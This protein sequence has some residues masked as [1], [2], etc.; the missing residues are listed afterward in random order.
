MTKVLHINS[1]YITTKLYRDLL[2]QLAPLGVLSTT[3]MF[4][5]GG[6][7]YV[8][9]EEDVIAVPTHNTLDRINYFT[10]HLKTYRDLDKRMKMDDQ[11]DVLHA[12]SLFSNGAIA[13]LISKKYKIPY[14]VAVRDT[15][16]NTFYK[17]MPWLRWIGRKVLNNAQKVVYISKPYR[18]YSIKHMV[19]PNKQNDIRERAVVLTNG[20]APFYLEDVKEKSAKGD[21]VKLLYV[22]RIN[23]RK[24]LETTIKACEALMKLGKKVEYTIVGTLE[25]KSL[26]WI[27]KKDYVIYISQVQRELLVDVYRHSDIF[28]MPS[29]TETFGLVYAEAISQG[30]PVIYTR[31]QG[32]DGNFQEGE[33]GYSVDTF[34]HE[35][36]MRAIDQIYLDYTSMSKRCATGSV[37]FDWSLIAQSYVEIY[38]EISK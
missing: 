2:N 32:F 29:I 22:G 13:Y 20:I 5:K 1:Y 18:E 36:I 19:K 37:K 38:K 4:Y 12:H 33:V 25:D 10:K 30:L 21:I 11:Y 24:N 35:Q 8:N 9:T 27:L 7:N 34:S 17:K 3:Y 26:S 15:D 14:V 31:G 6:I 23:K 16:V 28:I